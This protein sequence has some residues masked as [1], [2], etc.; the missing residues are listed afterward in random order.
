[1]TMTRLTL[2]RNARR[3]ATPIAVFVGAFAAGLAPVAD[4]DVWW[5]LAA[6][7]EMLRTR[8]ILTVDPFSVSAGGRPWVDVH[9]LF[10]LAAYA[11][12]AAG[13]LTA[14]VVA[15]CLL[16]AVGAVILERAVEREAG[17]RAGLPFAV[18]FL[19]A[20]FAVRPLLLLRPVVVTLVF[21]SLFFAQLESFRRK[22]RMAALAILPL[23]Q[24]AWTNFQG[25]FALGPAVVGAY[26][27][28][29]WLEARFGGVSSRA[30][31]DANGG[32]T[33]TAPWLPRTASQALALTLA[34]CMVGC[35]L[36]PYGVDALFLPLKLLGRLLPAHGNVYAANVIENVPPFAS[37]QAVAGAFWHL[38]CYFGFLVV[39]VALAGRRVVFPHVLLLAGFVL[40][41]LAGNRNVLLLY[42]IA[43]PIAVING[44]RGTS[45]VRAM[46]R[47]WRGSAALARWGSRGALV[48]L[49]L[50]LFEAARREPALAFPA[51]FRAPVESAR[52]LDGRAGTGT[53]FAADEYGGYLIWKLFPRYR[54]YIDTRLVLRTAAEF[55]EYLEVADHPERFDDF[56]ARHRFD[57]AIL[58]VA[59]PDRYLGL[60]AHLYSSPDWA[61][62]F[63]NGSEALFARRAIAGGERWD[64]GSPATTERMIENVQRQ[65]GTSPRLVEA[66]RLQLA[67]L[68][69][70][71]G[72][73]GEAEHLLVN[74]SSA[75]AEA[76]RARLHLASGDWIGAQTIGERLLKEDPRDVGSLDLMAMVSLRS[77]RPRPAVAFLRRALAAD[78]FDTEAE[79]ILSSLEQHVTTP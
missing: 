62:L 15:K 39:S 18:A 60:A 38:K 40:L 43:T 19:A 37:Q 45:R 23:L 5:H 75:D 66:A 48:A 21:L 8:S 73:F 71:V 52:L 11:T 1:M 17:P 27:I 58:P 13:G 41:A 61:L 16:V 53:I 51:P 65:F 34:F 56:Q 10:Q 25:L 50:L 32:A 28:G 26:V 79:R 46:V 74:V 36:T 64:L 30:L 22:R 14:L 54:P 49:L 35:C 76:L 31:A 3:H 42:W 78:P 12:H 29:T 9:W 7:R 72:E 44:W 63:A 4:G 68:D 47:H 57:Y 77:G 59:Y 6:G 20:L 67:T 2:L 55:A 69:I 70:T 24:I 33:R